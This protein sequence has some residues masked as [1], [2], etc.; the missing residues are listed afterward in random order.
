MKYGSWIPWYT[1]ICRYFGYDPERDY[2]ASV[3]LDKTVP[4]KSTDQ[5]YVEFFHGKDISVIGNGP[6]LREILDTHKISTSFVADSA[7]P[8]FYRSVGIPHVLVTDLDGD[9]ELIMK[10]LDEGSRI[11]LHAH[12]DNME[13]IREIGHEISGEILCTTQNRPFGKVYN[14]GGFTDGDR[15]AFLADYV[16]P[17]FLE[18][19]GFDFL[20]PV[21]KLNSDIRV[22]KEKLGYAKR[23][24]Q[25]LAVER[26]TIL[27]DG[28]V[29]AL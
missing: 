13:K 18:L 11:V 28:D 25:E 10:C 4:L 15:S 5:Q 19:V 2:H 12:G 22:K 20:N 24:L 21:N 29:I 23:L 26:G 7:L 6:R 14:F 3:L 8:V 17:R 27:K 16:K 1:E 9:Q